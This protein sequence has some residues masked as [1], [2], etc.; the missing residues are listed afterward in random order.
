MGA[1]MTDLEFAAAVR[2]AKGKAPQGM[3][4]FAVREIVRAALEAAEAVRVRALQSLHGR[5]DP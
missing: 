2:A 1:R 5:R 3:G 4:D